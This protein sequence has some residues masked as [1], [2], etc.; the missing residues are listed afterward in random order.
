[1]SQPIPEFTELLQQLIDSAS[2]SC[3]DPTIDMSNTGVIN[4]LANW[5]EDLGFSVRIQEIPGHPNK[6]NLIAQLGQGDNGLILSG[7]SD[8]VPVNA[9][10][11]Q[12]DPL[13][14]T[15]HNDRLYGLGSCDMKGFLALAVDACRELQKGQLQRPLTLVASADEESSMSGARLLAENGERLGRY[16]LIGEP[17]GLRPVRQHKGILMEAIHLHGQSGHSSN[18]ALGNSAL[19]GMHLLMQR[20][21]DFRQQLQ[22][23]F[24]NE[25]FE[26]PVPTLNLGHIHGGDNPNRICG[27]CSINFDLRPL[28]GM[29]IDELRQQVRNL[30]QTVAQERGLTA[31]CEALFDGIPAMHTDANAHLVQY[32]EHWSGS[33][34]DAVAFGTEAPY[35]QQLGAETVVLGPG[36]INQA[37]QPDE[38][39]PLAHLGPMQK[40]LQQLI[41]DHCLQPQPDSQP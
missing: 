37:H 12:S 41:L 39:L 14:L 30:A 8:T 32:L 19:E 13:Q 23:Q 31:H 6:R 36:S 33:R 3:V 20:L 7:H 22:Q 18:P 27:D 34:A 9:D 35:F 40:L 38:F 24:R 26:I 21:L 1:M 4:L 16:C 15:R 25:A 11:W 10:L 2:I 29:S 17:T 5:L 28:P